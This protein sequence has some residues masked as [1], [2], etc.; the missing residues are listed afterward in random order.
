ME[1]ISNC[2]GSTIL[3]N[4]DTIC[5][6]RESNS[7]KTIKTAII[8]LLLIFIFIASVIGNILV[9]LVFC[10]KPTL[11]T[12]SN[13]F[14]LNLTICNSLNTVIIMPFMFVTMI[15]EVWVFGYVWCKATGFFM[16]TIFAASTLTLVAI[17]IDRYCAVATPLHYA[18]KI[19]RKRAVVMTISVW[20]VAVVLS[21][22][23]LFGWN[24]YVFQADKASCTV[25]W[26][27]P[28]K[29]DKF[30]TLFLVSVSF[31]LPL[32]VILWGYIIIFKAARNNSERTRRNSFIPSNQIEDL[33]QMPLKD[34]RRRPC[35]I[36]RPSSMPILLRRRSSSSRTLPLLWKRDEWKTALTSF[37]VVFTFVICWL[38]YFI[39]IILES[40]LN[41]PE[42]IPAEVETV[43]ILLAMSS[44]AINPLV[45]V[46]WNNS[47]R[48]ELKLLL[49]LQ[50]RQEFN[51][52]RRGSTCT[53]LRDGIIRQG[54][55]DSDII[56]EKPLHC[57]ATNTTLTSL[58]CEKDHSQNIM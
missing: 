16:N 56:L 4:G 26:A 46:F 58:V 40:V 24:E 21:L 5:Y 47:A 44:C 3:E 42:S 37:L 34:D 36:S 35:N 28:S 43:S 12:I 6:D 15:S 22:P 55:S 54:S 32:I 10:K 1:N 30:Y 53:M 8:A 13:R 41:K 18:M 9:F 48:Q 27:T 17:S 11:L 38:P 29:W 19:T 31:A 49:R 23:P 7:V 52:S 51:E 2:T 25:L 20:C 57:S 39:I 33:S 50:R 45:Y 14:I